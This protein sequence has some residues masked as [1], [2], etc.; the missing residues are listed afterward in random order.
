MAAVVISL[1]SLVLA[2]PS[3]LAALVAGLTDG[4]SGYSPLCLTDGAGIEL[5]D[6]GCSVNPADRNAP[7]GCLESGKR[8][9]GPRVHYLHV[10]GE[11]SSR[12]VTALS[13]LSPLLM[14]R[15]RPA[16]SGSDE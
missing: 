7:A 14:N 6:P 11:S 10:I 13:L 3:G 8:K 4:D 1:S 2:F 9:R 16:D 15:E 12:N 5:L